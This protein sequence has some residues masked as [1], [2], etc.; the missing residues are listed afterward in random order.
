MYYVCRRR[1]V[2]VFP[3]T[4]T[5]LTRFKTAPF[6]SIVRAASET[7]IGNSAV[8]HLAFNGD[9]EAEPLYVHFDRVGH[10]TSLLKKFHNGRDFWVKPIGF[11]L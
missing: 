10:Y 7:I 9:E 8:A 4:P 5:D 3:F 1:V 2:T 6:P 11:R